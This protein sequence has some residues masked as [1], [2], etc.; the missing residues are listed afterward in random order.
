MS[1]KR[2]FE[3]PEANTLNPGDKIAIDKSG[4]TEA[5]CIDA[6]IILDQFTDLTNN[7]ANKS[8]LTSISITG[9]KNNTGSTITS[10]S[11]FY[12]DGTLVRAKTDIANNATLTLNTNYEIVTAGGLNALNNAL[13]SIESSKWKFGT[14]VNLSLYNH[15][16][17]LF[18][19][20]QDGYIQVYGGD[21]SGFAHIV[22]Y[23]N[24]TTSSSDANVSIYAPAG[25]KNSLF[26]KKG[27]K[28]HR[29]NDGGTNVTF[30][31][32]PLIKV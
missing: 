12:K 2:I 4:N 25:Q 11:F 17:N 13:T 3:L 22:V 7:K 18:E 14:Q 27:Q 24:D 26:V 5:K 28:V 8:D 30:W 23:G 29:V 15:Y 6:S 9:S 31:Y 16:G 20:P 21:A 32:T 19:I 10:G 1:D